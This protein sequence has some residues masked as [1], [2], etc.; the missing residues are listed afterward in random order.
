MPSPLCHAEIERGML[1]LLERHGF[2][3]LRDQR[4]L[5]V[6]CG[7]GVWRAHSSTGG[8]RRAGW[9]ASICRRA[10]RGSSPSRT[11]GDAVVT[12]SAAELA[13]PDQSFDIVLQSLMFTSIL[14]QTV[15]SRVAGEWFAWCGPAA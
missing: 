5:D 13:F 12:G 11:A 1:Q 9:P 6:G 15:R 3:P 8:R 10:H 2:T 4:I 14:D 7:T